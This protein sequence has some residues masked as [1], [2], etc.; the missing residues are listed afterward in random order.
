MIRSCYYK[1]AEGKKTVLD[2]G[3]ARDKTLRVTLGEET[4][5]AWSPADRELG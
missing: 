4:F 3:N 1:E 5:A 2:E